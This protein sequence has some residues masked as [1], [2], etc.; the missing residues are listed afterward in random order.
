ML[1]VPILQHM[2]SFGE[3]NWS[4]NE[5]RNTETKNRN[6]LTMHDLFYYT[7]DKDKLYHK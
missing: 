2:S 7:A 3:I 1:A 6:L 4:L 5:L